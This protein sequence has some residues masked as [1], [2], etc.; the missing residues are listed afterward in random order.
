MDLLSASKI[1]PVSGQLSF[2]PPSTSIPSSIDTTHFSSQFSHFTDTTQNI[3]AAFKSLQAKVKKLQKIKDE[4]VR[5]KDE[6]EFRVRSA[7]REASMSRQEVNASTERL[8]SHLQLTH[9]RSLSLKS[10]LVNSLSQEK[11]RNADL[12]SFLDRMKSERNGQEREG[13]ELEDSTDRL[14]HE[15]GEL[16]VLIQRVEGQCSI[17]EARLKDEEEVSGKREREVEVEIGRQGRVLTK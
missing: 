14:E 8:F 17:L 6:M 16:K 2:S 4:V 12:S 9:E 5:E 11:K 7:E 15:E 13:G 10:D 1:K 3:V